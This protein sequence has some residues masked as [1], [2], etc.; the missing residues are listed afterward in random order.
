MSIFHRFT[1]WLRHVLFNIFVV[2]LSFVMPDNGKRMM[3]MTSLYVKMKGIVPTQPETLKPLVDD[4][5]VA[6]K[7]TELMFPANLIICDWNNDTLSKIQSAADDYGNLKAVCMSIV[8]NTPRMLQYGRKDDM[9][10]DM[11]R[12]VNITQCHSEA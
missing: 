9:V 4:L 5:Q 10:A 6:S 7:P 12:V 2:I 11:I 3:F 8:N 1:A